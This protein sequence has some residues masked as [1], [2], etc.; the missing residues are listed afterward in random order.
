MSIQ[1]IQIVILN[2]S[3][4]AVKK[5]ERQSTALCHY[6]DGEYGGLVTGLQRQWLSITEACI[7]AHHL[8]TLS[9]E[10][11]AI[12]SISVINPHHSSVHYELSAPKDKT[13]KHLFIFF[14]SKE[15]KA[16]SYAYRTLRQTVLKNHPVKVKVKYHNVNFY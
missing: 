14:E 8:A 10:G 6:Q 1:A 5:F 16:R 3:L 11:E 12:N 4:K 13:L 9:D 2:H 7:V 15:E